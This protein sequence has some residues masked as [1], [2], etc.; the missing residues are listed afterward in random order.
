MSSSFD[1][2]LDALG[3][4][5]PVLPKVDLNFLSDLDASQVERLRKLWTRLDATRRREIM[6]ELGRLAQEHIEL[7]FD[8]VDRMALSDPDSEVRRFAIDNLWESEDPALVPALVRGVTAD[9]EPSVRAAAAAA[10]GAFVYLGEVDRLP[11]EALA[12]VER[13][14]LHAV[15]DADEIVRLR[16]LESL[17][18]S[19]R[20]EVPSLIR[21]A[22]RSTAES[23]RRSSLLA[24]ARSADDAWKTEVLAELRSPSPL[25]RLEATKAAGELELQE[26]IRELI[27]LVEDGDPGIHRAAIW[28]LGQVGGKRPGEFLSRLLE[29]T[30]DGDEAGLIED[31]LDQ[32]AFVEGTRELTL[33]DVDEDDEETDEVDEDEVEVEIEDEIETEDEEPS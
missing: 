16:S 23:R 6:G 4:P 26:S 8:R 24:M 3:Q 13:A 2:L 33:L 17:G 32:L 29:A 1:Q 11:A 9:S 19:S 20:A 14:L 25:L 5:S 15:Q 22:Y 21:E 30:E 27:D 18:Y 12:E 7:N 31:A 28:S 10:L